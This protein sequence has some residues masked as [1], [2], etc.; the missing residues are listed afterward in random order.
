MNASSI[1]KRSVGLTTM[2]AVASALSA[3]W[4]WGRAREHEGS[5]HDA[6]GCDGNVWRLPKAI[7]EAES[8][9]RLQ[10]PP[11]RSP[12]SRGDARHRDAELRSGVKTRRDPSRAPYALAPVPLAI[13]WSTRVLRTGD[14]EFRRDE[15]PVA[16]TAEHGSD[17]HRF[18]PTAP[19]RM[20]RFRLLKKCASTKWR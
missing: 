3:R 9:R 6:T 2:S 18:S 11:A 1:M 20:L 14:R 8:E 12:S 17:R 19:F 10:Q 5:A 4:S 7:A 15:E 13:R 16:R